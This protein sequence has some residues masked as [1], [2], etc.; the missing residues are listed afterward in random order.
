MPGKA[1]SKRQFRFFKAVAAGKA[2]APGLSPS[3]AEEML[4]SQSQAGLPERAPAK[5]KH[6]RGWRFK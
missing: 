5:A 1:T 4:G 3:K 2:K 6:K